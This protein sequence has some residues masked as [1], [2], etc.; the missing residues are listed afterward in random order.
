M[1]KQFPS[2]SLGKRLKSML[3]VD[4]RRMFTTR[5]FYIMAGICLAAPILILVM[6]TMMDGSVSVD[7]Q[8]GAETIVHGFDSVWQIIGTVSGD[9]SAAAGG[10][11]MTAMCNINLLYFGLAVLVGLFVS[12]DFKSGYAKNLF[13]VRARKSDYVISKTLVCFMAAVLLFVLFFIGTLIGGAMSGLPFALD[14]LTVGNLVLCLL[15]KLLLTLVFVPIFL[16]VSVAAKQKTWLAIVGSGAI[17]MLLFMMIPALTPLN[18]TVMNAVLCLA[19]GVLFS[20]GL[21]AVSKVVLSR[22]AL[23]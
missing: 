1:E 13:T 19:G 11:S 10:M 23:V 17:G 3:K 21:G 6:T 15:S 18:A 4:L 7:P 2:N 5:L 20:V 9:S 16:A 14:S 22:T 8:T 12:A